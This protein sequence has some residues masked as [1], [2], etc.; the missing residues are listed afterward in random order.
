MAVFDNMNYTHS[1]GVAPAVV[2]YY[3]RK[4]L[5]NAKKNLVHCRDLQKRVLP[6]NNGRRVQFRR[7]TPFPPVTEPLMEGVTPDGQTLSMTSF[8]VM[9]K[10]YGRHVELTDEMDWAMLNNMHREASQ[11]LADQA[12]ESIDAIARNALHAGLNVQYANGKTARSAIEA[13][14]KLTYEEIKKAV[15]TLKKNN[16]RRFPDGCYHAI[17]GMEA[18]Y[19]LTSDPM[20]VDVAKYSDKE[21]VETYELGRIFGVKFFESTESMKFT[22]D[23]YLFGTKASL[24][25]TAFDATAGVFTVAASALGTTKAEQIHACAQLSGKLVDVKTGSDTSAT[26]TPVCIERAD[27]D[28]SNAKLKLRWIPE[29]T[30]GFG[31]ATIVPGGAG[32]SGAT[33]YSTIVY[34]QDFGGCVELEGNGKNVEIIVNPVGS[35]GA[36]D[37]LKQRGTV[38][39]KVKGFAA[40]ILQDAFG[41]RI[42][43]GATA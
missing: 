42:E 21:Q 18:V 14:D 30:T 33:V 27:I 4:L 11:V 43:H 41:V 2:E 29:S 35:S 28:G 19:D 15:R 23:A 39:W 6:K 31:T 40:A 16:A 10:P 24:T 22:G 38:A 7:M 32:K 3:E 8:T 5:E 36:L 20:W 12:V 1:A 25:A 13:S 9:V 34:G 17:I 37:P 26:V